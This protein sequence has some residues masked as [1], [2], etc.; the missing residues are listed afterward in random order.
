MIFG[1]AFCQVRQAAF[2]ILKQCVLFGLVFNLQLPG[3]TVIVLA[4]GQAEVSV[5]DK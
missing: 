5:L 3:M 4:L 1:G 2:N